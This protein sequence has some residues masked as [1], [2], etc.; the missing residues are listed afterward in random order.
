MS[1]VARLAFV[2]PGRTIKLSNYLLNYSYNNQNKLL[3]SGS[4]RSF[5]T[6]PEKSKLRKFY[7]EYG[8]LGIGVYLGISVISVSSIY[9]AIKLGVDVNS[10]LEKFN[11]QDNKLVS[12]AGPF[13]LAYGIH[14]VFAPARLLLAFVI[15]PIIK[16]R[17]F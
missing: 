4:F 7:E 10:V 11:L 14:K 13:A 9:T 6:Q 17:F 1:Q 15:T 5:S 16:R 2:F 12:K 3:A 8:K